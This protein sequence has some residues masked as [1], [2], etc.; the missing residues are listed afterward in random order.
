M[1]DLSTGTVYDG[2]DTV[3]CTVSEAQWSYSYGVSDLAS[4]RYL[5]CTIEAESHAYIG[6]SIS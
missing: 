4:S 1:V 2:V 5:M 6:N 3:A